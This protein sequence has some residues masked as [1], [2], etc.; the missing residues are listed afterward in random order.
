M[1]HRGTLTYPNG[2]KYEG[3]FNGTSPH[4][5]GTLTFKDGSKFEGQIKDGLKHGH[6]IQTFKEQKFK[7]RR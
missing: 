4:G 5:K 1:F 6:G 7:P 3:E 2:D